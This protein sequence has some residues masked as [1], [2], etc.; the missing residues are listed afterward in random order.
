MQRQSLGGVSPNAK[1]GGGGASSKEDKKPEETELKRK[2]LVLL[3]KQIDDE[4]NKVEKRAANSKTAE[5]SIHLIPI[6][7][8][9]CLLILYLFSYDP[10]Q[11]DLAHING[12]QKPSTKIDMPEMNELDKF[13]DMKKGDVLG[14]RS[15]RSLLKHKMKPRPHRRIGDF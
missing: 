1:H 5:K 14:I 10:A 11:T 4:E 2:D 7:I 3:G 8:L 13:V 12:F 15:H 9:L 6:L